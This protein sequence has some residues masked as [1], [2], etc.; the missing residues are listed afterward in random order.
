M[1]QEDPIVL[2]SS[3]DDEDEGSFHS[4]PVENSTE[5]EP[6]G[7][8]PRSQVDSL[9]VLD[10]DENDGDKD[11]SV[12]LCELP[13]RKTHPPPK[14]ATHS[15]S[16]NNDED[17]DGT[18]TLPIASQRDE[19]DESS[20]DDAVNEKDVSDDQDDVLKFDWRLN[21]LG[22]SSSSS[23]NALLRAVSSSSSSISQGINLRQ[24]N[25][26]PKKK[27]KTGGR[28]RQDEG[29]DAPEDP[30]Q[31]KLKK[32]RKGAKTEEEK[33]AIALALGKHR[34]LEV[35]ILCH[36]DFLRSPTGAAFEY[37]LIEHDRRSNLT[38]GDTILKDMIL[39]RRH[40][41]EIDSGDN[42]VR[43]SPSKHFIERCAII[44][45]SGDEVIRDLKD[46]KTK[47]ARLD[48]LS[49]SSRLVQS[50]KLTDHLPGDETNFV[51]VLLDCDGALSRHRV[52]PRVLEDFLV[53]D[54][55]IGMG[56]SFCHVKDASEAAD[57]CFQF[58]ET[59]EGWPY[60][61]SERSSGFLDNVT[62]FKSF[63]SSASQDLSEEKR[64]NRCIDGTQLLSIWT[65][66]LRCFPQVSEQVAESIAQHYPSFHSMFTAVRT[67]PEEVELTLQRVRGD[68][69]RERK[70]ARSVCKLFLSDDC[71]DRF[72]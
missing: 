30:K 71:E 51:I 34:E 58:C 60:R 12:F 56:M 64:T 50:L 67:N 16:S 24:L 43:A 65:N 18:G 45:W 53:M 55:N 19:G 62:R 49:E 13:W 28:Q 72:A 46:A 41:L 44:V 63:S 52:N 9:V 10:D 26:P 38:M 42:S 11:D 29:E 20:G 70:L 36:P 54:V 6:N 40:F 8:A 14:P 2:D 1:S 3:S 15:P 25:E 57:V 17:D 32:P 31:P 7:E 23:S 47:Q 27:R 69:R 4:L 5:E 61:K 22:A 68:Q 21:S 48:S 37:Y 39:F 33:L 66:Q 59:V 35:R